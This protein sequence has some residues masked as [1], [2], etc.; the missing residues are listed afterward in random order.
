MNTVFQ[1]QRSVSLTWAARRH[2]WMTSPCASTWSLMS[3]N[4]CHQRLWRQGVSAP[5]STWWSTAA[6]MPS[7]CV[8]VYTPST[9]TAST[10]CCRALG[11][12]GESP[13]VWL[14]G[15]SFKMLLFLVRRKEG[16]GGVVTKK[17]GRKLC[18]VEHWEVKGGGG[19]GGCC[20]FSLQG[21]LGGGSVVHENRGEGSE[22]WLKDWSPSYKF[23]VHCNG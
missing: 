13:C 15:A 6:R 1:I 16:E 17:A 12:I 9:S 23:L 2:V 7:T 20:D 5:T 3:M 10:R 21:E 19:G 22:L 4:S 14:C 18:G 8:C 11:L